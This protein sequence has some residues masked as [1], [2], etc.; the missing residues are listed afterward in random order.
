RLTGVGYVPEGHVEHEGRAL[1][2]G[3][4]HAEHVVVL[5][6]GSLAGNADLRQASSG[7]WQIQGDPTEAAFLVAERKLG[8]SERR[9]RRFERVEEIPFSSERKMMSTIE[10]DREQGGALVVITKGAPDLLIEHC[11]RVRVGA[12]VVPLDDTLRARALGDVQRLLDESL[13]TLSVAYR[14]LDPGEDPRSGELLE[15]ELIF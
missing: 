11:T 4:L 5:S 3:P 9:E 6:G 13:R 8:V 10:R 12:S 7:E 2:P 1:T 15:R 14:P